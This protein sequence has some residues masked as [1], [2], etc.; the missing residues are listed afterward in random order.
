[1]RRDH[2]DVVQAVMRSLDIYLRRVGPQALGWYV[3]YEGDW[4][5]LDERGWAFVRSA[6][7]SPDGANIALSQ[8]PESFTGH[9]FSY[10]GRLVSA[11]PPMSRP[12]DTCVV[13]FWLPTEYMEEHGPQRVRELAL[14]LAAGLPFN[15]GSAGL[16]YSFPESLLGIT[17]SIREVCFRYPGIDLANSFIGGDIGTRVQGAHWLTFLGP[18]VLE[19]LGGVEGLRAKL[20]SPGTTV[21]TLDDERAVAT[22][23]L[24]PEAGDLDEG[25]TLPE[26]RELARVLEPWLYE[27]TSAWQ[28]FSAEDM[29][30]WYRRFLD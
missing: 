27:G 2:P 6:F 14:E 23:G 7:L 15:S 10:R 30:R 9:D 1:M 20:R 18:P 19:A 25:R 17:P 26:Y 16:C 22:L 21:Q 8:S 5:Q 13:T 11:P 29:R 28:G 3:D 24:W 4:Q 12:G